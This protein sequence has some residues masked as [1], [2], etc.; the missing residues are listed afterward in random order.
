LWPP[1]AGKDC[2][3]RGTLAKWLLQAGF[4]GGGGEVLRQVGPPVCCA[5]LVF[6]PE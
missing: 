3:L 2:W 1:L 4:E 5:A 6:F